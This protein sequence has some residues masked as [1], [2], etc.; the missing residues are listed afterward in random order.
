MSKMSRVLGFIILLT[1][2]L[3]ILIILFALPRNCKQK[4]TIFEIINYFMNA[5]NYG[6]QLDLETE[7]PQDTNQDQSQQPIT[8]KKS[9]NLNY[10]F[11]EYPDKCYDLQIFQLRET[12]NSDKEPDKKNLKNKNGAPLNAIIYT[13]LLLLIGFLAFD[14]LPLRQKHK[15]VQKKE[16]EGKDSRRC[17]LH[18]YKAVQTNRDGKH[19]KIISRKSSTIWNSSSSLPLSD[20]S[21]VRNSK[22]IRGELRPLLRRAS[23]SAVQ[24]PLDS[25][26]DSS[27]DVKR[28]VRMLHRH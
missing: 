1:F 8:L 18:D 27:P 24:I 21:P 16:V 11:I 19:N 28:R 10:K 7:L 4:S 9:S 12:K 5:K 23:A 14:Y 6:Q 3:I 25:E 26:D 13:V 17:S 2:L 22:F 15:N 20:M